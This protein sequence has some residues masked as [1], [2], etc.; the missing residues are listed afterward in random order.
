M[1][2]PDT[3]S[4]CESV[5]A[6]LR[7]VID[8]AGI[9]PPA[10]LPLKTAWRAYLAY[11]DTEDSWMLAHFV[12]AAC[13]LKTLASFPSEAA[14]DDL[15][16]TL[17]VIGRPAAT[18]ADWFTQ[19]QEDLTATKELAGL[20]A[21]QATIAAL[22]VKLPDDVVATG[23][24]AATA[25]FAQHAVE[26]LHRSEL[27]S[28]GLFLELPLEPIGK[29]SLEQHIAGLADVARENSR[30]TL[31]LKLRT[32]GLQPTAFPTLNQVA[33]VIDACRRHGLAWKATAGLH[34]PIRQHRPEVDGPMHGFVNV[35]AAMVLAAV[36]E[37]PVDRLVKILADETP[38]HFRF[39]A[40]GLT[41]NGL[42]ASVLQIQDARQ[43]GMISFGSCSFEEPS[44]DLRALGWLPR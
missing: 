20:M 18:T 2:S 3:T 36:H 33:H 40:A 37:L 10:R 22:E 15:P 1:A 16:A 11:R 39:T 23:T 34:H 30:G 43:R 21:G 24:S 12:V 8:Y 14:P 19:W 7:D 9:Y 27:D 5:Q 38:D 13:E 28:T 35:L 41:W 29:T 4:V 31:G 17:A 32:G 25:K 42:S 44:D 6:L 26:R